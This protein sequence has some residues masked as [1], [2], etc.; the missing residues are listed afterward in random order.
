[1]DQHIC[2]DC[3]RE[4][5]GAESLNQHRQAKH[6]VQPASTAPKK[7]LPWKLILGALVL[8]VI[9]GS[10]TAL[11]KSH[12]GKQVLPN[13]NLDPKEQQL[14]NFNLGSMSESSFGMHIHPAVHISINGMEQRI[15]PNIGISPGF[16][17]V[18]HTHDDSGVIHVESPELYQFKLRDFFIVWGK[19]FNQTCIFDYCVDDGHTLTLTVNGAPSNE[20]GDLVLKDGDQ[21]RI[22]Y[23]IKI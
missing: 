6:S 9:I 8:L 3:K 13:E 5:Q 22:S 18:L 16:M 19:N 11:A 12:S 17:H 7:K 14:L 10:L 4:F 2:T 1:M 23:D 15:P 20:F 21:I